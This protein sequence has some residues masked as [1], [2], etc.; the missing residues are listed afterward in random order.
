MP[1]LRSIIYSSCTLKRKII[2]SSTPPPSSIPKCDAKRH[3][4][5]VFHLKKTMLTNSIIWTT[6]KHDSLRPPCVYVRPFVNSLCDTKY[7]KQCCPVVNYVNYVD[8]GVPIIRPRLVSNPRSVTSIT[9][10]TTL[11]CNE[12]YFFFW[13][14]Y[15][16]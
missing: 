14:E 13:Y 8:L 11:S 5:Y 1:L 10:N 4:A 6:N 12:R 16:Y 2:M 15:T 7:H 9:V 3:N